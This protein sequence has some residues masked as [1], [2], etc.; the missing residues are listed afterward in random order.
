M[1]RQRS[2]A[3]RLVPA[4]LVAAAMAIPGATAEDLLAHAPASTTLV[5]LS[6]SASGGLSPA[7][8]SGSGKTATATSSTPAGSS[9][10]SGSTPSTAASATHTIST[11]TS[12]SGGTTPHSATA[13]PTAAVSSGSAGTAAS[14]ATTRPTPAASSGAGVTATPVATATSSAPKTYAGTAEQNRFGTVQVTLVVTG[15]KVT[16]V[17]VTAP[18]DNPRSASINAYAVP[19]LRS[20]TLQAQS[21]TIDAVSGATYTSE[22]YIGSLQAALAAAKL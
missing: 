22:S 21:A 8:S 1:K 18:Q 20:E 17:I 12:S 16:D 13:S 7:G 11:G 10:T 19:I 2:K 14:A 4:L 15:N 6:P 3:A 5:A 9:G